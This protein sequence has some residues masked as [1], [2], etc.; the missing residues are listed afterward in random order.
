MLD[1]GCGQGVLGRFLA[2]EGCRVVGIDAAETL[3]AKARQR[4]KTD[5]LPV[6]YIVADV[7]KLLDETGRPPLKSGT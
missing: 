1:L 2:R 6:N 7:T 4:N 3:V 5:K